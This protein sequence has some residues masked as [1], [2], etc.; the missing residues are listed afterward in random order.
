[1]TVITDPQEKIREL[2]RELTELRDENYG[3]RTQL[4]GDLPRATA[5]LQRKAWSQRVALARLV[6]RNTRLRWQLRQVEA[7]GR[8]LSREEY[9]TAR[10]E[11]SNHQ[12]AVLIGDPDA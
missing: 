4:E 7:L 11:E 3:L 2:Q 5:W 9:L 6:Q 8:G 1:M 10:M 12:V